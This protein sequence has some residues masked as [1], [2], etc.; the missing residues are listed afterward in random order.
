MNAV[1]YEKIA[2]VVGV[3]AP[4]LELQFLNGTKCPEITNFNELMRELADKKPFLRDG[5]TQGDH[6]PGKHGKP[7]KLRHSKNCEN[8]KKNLREYLIFFSEKPGKLMENV[9]YL[10]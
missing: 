5:I 1:L 7:R 9:K 3:R 2:S 4:N 6:K 10:T 8:F